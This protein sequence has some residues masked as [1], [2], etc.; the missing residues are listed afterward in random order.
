MR[1]EKRIVYVIPHRCRYLSGTKVVEDEHT[2]V[3]FG[4][5]REWWKSPLN[6]FEVEFLD[7]LK[8]HMI[9]ASSSQLVRLD[10]SPILGMT[11][12]RPLH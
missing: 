12:L 10:T 7:R 9:E 1:K 8:R 5:G 3:L 11:R 4:V 2:L 6:R